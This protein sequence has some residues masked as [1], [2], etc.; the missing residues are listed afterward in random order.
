M[1]D[2]AGGDRHSAARASFAAALYHEARG[3][4]DLAQPLLAAVA[5]LDVDGDLSGLARCHL[6]MFGAQRPSVD[7]GKAAEER[8]GEEGEREE[9]LRE[10]NK[11]E[12][13]GKGKGKGAV[14]FLQQVMVG[15]WGSPRTLSL[16]SSSGEST[17]SISTTEGCCCAEEEEAEMGASVPGPPMVAS[18]SF[19]W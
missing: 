8:K 7:K 3:E 13:K 18:R 12:E 9:K 15:A 16:D 14:S 11:G 19:S 5:R 10:G 17:A 6:A 4:G 2:A 1:L